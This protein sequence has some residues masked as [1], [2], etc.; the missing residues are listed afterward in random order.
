V[1]LC[2]PHRSVAANAADLFAICLDHPKEL[3]RVAAA[4][5]ST[6]SAVALATLEERG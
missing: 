1:S 6:R 2:Y 5:G 3:V 4:I